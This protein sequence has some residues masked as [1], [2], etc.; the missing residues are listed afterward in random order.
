M[1]TKFPSRTVVLVCVVFVLA[2]ISLTLFVWRS[3]GGPIPL[4]AKQ[5]EVK[6]LFSNASQLSPNADVRISGVSVGRVTEVRSKGLRTEATIAVDTRFAPLPAD[7]RAILRQKTLLGETFVALTP[8]TKNGRILADGG[9]IP[10]EQIESTQTLDRVLQ[11]LDADGRKRLQELLVDTG[12]MLEGRSADIND[13]VGNLAT[14]TRQLTG[15]MTLL[16]DQRDDVTQLT[17]RVGEVLQT[18]G[19]ES[20]SVQQLVRAGNDALGATASRD[21][22]LRETV[23]AAPAFLAELRRTSTRAEKTAGVAAPVLRDFR[24]VAPDVAPAL[25]ALERGAPQIDALLRDLEAYVPQAQKALPPAAKLVNAL[26]PF[27]DRL[28]PAARQVTPIISYIGQYRKELVGAMANVGATMNG[29]SP[30]VT[31]KPTRYI[32]TI[33]PLAPSTLVGASSRNGE[34]RTNA[35]MAPGGLDELGKGGLLS[36]D[37]RHA[38]KGTIASAPP[39]KEQPGWSFEGGP[40]RYF[41]RLQERPVVPQGIETLRALLGMDKPGRLSQKP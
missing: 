15:L 17:A 12:T 14:G 27:M 41:Q 1:I 26:T 4:E 38:S 34:I 19:D 32:R 2:S 9:S 23:E 35:Y 36:S 11:T 16:D 10:V 21:R 7:T 3:L 31:G 40:P 5:Y 33:I 39:C 37:C 29:K 13:A 25:K 24:P 30:G 20:A 18:V 8:G 22:R 28:E 6:G